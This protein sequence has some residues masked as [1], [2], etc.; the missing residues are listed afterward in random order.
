MK[1][2]KEGLLFIYLFPF[3]F[4]LGYFEQNPQN[5][6]QFSQTLNND[7]RY[8]DSQT[9]ECGTHVYSDFLVGMELRPIPRL[10]NAQTSIPPSSS[11]V[12]SSPTWAAF[13]SPSSLGTSVPVSPLIWGPHESW[14]PANPAHHRFIHFTAIR[15]EY[16]K[17]RNKKGKHGRMEQSWR[18]LW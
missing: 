12:G 18:D 17:R 1:P 5:S 11:K 10:S 15:I 16:Q 2:S 6:N 14:V 4:L 7:K 8:W 13:R 3:L 9:N